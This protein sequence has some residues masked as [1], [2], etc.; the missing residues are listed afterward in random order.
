MQ[1]AK[2]VG[3][4]KTVVTSNRDAS[5]VQGTIWL[6]SAT[7]RK[8]PVM[9]NVSYVVE[10]I[11]QITRHVLSTK[12]YIKNIPTTS[13]ET[14]HYSCTN[15][16]C[17]TNSTRNYICANNQ[18]KFLRVCWSSSKALSKART[19]WR[20][21]QYPRTTVHSRWGLQCKAYRLGIQAYFIQRMRTTQN[22]GK[23]ELKIS[24]HG[25]THIL[26]IWQEH[27]I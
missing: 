21:L 13:S 11:P 16:K 2:G 26:A 24:I 5:N 17:P 19:I 12:S 6:T 9:S 10:T 22:G 14:I 15:K 8:D 18:A 7:V 25:G 20:F 23:H 27:Q 3:T 4:P 1:I